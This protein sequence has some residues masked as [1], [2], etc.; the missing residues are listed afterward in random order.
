[1]QQYH[2]LRGITSDILQEVRSIK[3]S[4]NRVEPTPGD[5]ATTSFFK[6]LEFQF[7]I[8]LE[9]DLTMFNQLLEE[10][11]NFKN[12]VNSSTSEQTSNNKQ[13]HYK[14]S[15]T[16]PSSIAKHP[17]EQRAAIGYPSPL[18]AMK[19]PKEKLIYVVCVQPNKCG[20]KTDHL[21]TVDVDPCSPT[22]CKI[23][24]RTYS[25]SVDDEFHHSGW[26]IC[27][28]CYHKKCCHKQ[29]PPR[30][31]LI[32]PALRSSRIYVIDTGRNP[33]APEI[34]RIIDPV[35]LK[36]LNCTYPHTTHCLPT[37]EIMIS[38]MG[39]NNGDGKGEFVLID[40]KTYKVKGTWTVGET[41]KFGYDYWYQPYH[42]VLIASEWT[43]PNIF[44]QGFLFKHIETD[45]IYGKSL[46]FYSWST[47]KLLQSVDLGRDGFSPLEV[48]FLHDPK[49]C[50]GF[51]GT[52]VFAVIYRFYKKSDGT[53]DAHKV[54]SIPPKKVTG[55]IAE[56]MPGLMTDILVSLDDKYLYISN[57]LH[58]DVRQYNITDREHPKL[59]GQIFLGGS[60]LSDSNVKVVEDLEL[61]KQP[62][63]VYIKGKRLNGSPQMLQLSLDGKRLYVSS[64]LY[65]AWDR[66][67]YPNEVENGG[68]LVKLDV[69]VECGGMTLDKEFLVDFSGGPDG[70]LLPHE[71]RFPEGDSTS[72]IWL[73]ED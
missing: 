15:S 58:G 18:A 67:L 72:D 28:S 13:Q 33:R 25:L 17:H 35:E 2:I 44:N 23:I 55:W 30:D 3:E 37:G 65:S 39:D 43:A 66:Q 19:G 5:A 20:N 49:E 24:H 22:F 32:L 9:E 36:A 16:P 63:P 51:V 50:Q 1:M 42:D 64:S 7:P 59:T 31:K 46:N 73:V 11:E 45:D 21:A 38:T 62:D 69:D 71:M 52:A 8:N 12:A 6:I 68:F 56:S 29:F 40:A 47:R 57:W 27:S 54:V 48:R 14:S 61:T 10:E 53:W 41:A 34:D 60:I 26:N 70:P 4:L